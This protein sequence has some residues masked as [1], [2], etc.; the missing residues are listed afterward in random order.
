[1]YVLPWLWHYGEMY[2]HTRLHPAHVIPTSYLLTGGGGGG[3]IGLRGDEGGGGEEGDQ[4]RMTPVIAWVLGA[5]C[6]SI[7]L[8]TEVRK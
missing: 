8:V 1:M 5:T 7:S 6:G 3:D 4:A 2:N